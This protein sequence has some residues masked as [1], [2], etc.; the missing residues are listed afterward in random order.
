VVK[1]SRVRKVFPVEGHYQTLYRLIKSAVLGQPEGGKTFAALDDINFELFRGEKVGLIGNN[2]AGKSTL[3]KIVAGLQKPTIGE[4]CVSGQIALLTGYEVGLVEELT[5]TENVFLYGAIH[6]M[7]REKIKNK[8]DDII[9]W[10]D[11]GGFLRAKL[12]ALSTGMATRLAFSVA[13]HVDAEVIL[14]DEALTAGDKN[15]SKKCEDYFEEAKTASRTFL[16][17]THDLSFV[18]NF[19]NKAL[20]LEKGR[21]A[22]FGDANDV[23]QQ[24]RT[25]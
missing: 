15:F 23:M 20:W 12:K 4:V 22:A 24:Y 13:R 19:C 8:F 5:V 2:G 1:V 9:R 10:A 21:Q 25:S 6:G 17:A 14:L 3:L 11:L 16:V 18:Q 7:D